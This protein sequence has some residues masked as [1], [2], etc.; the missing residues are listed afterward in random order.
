MLLLQ[1]CW[2]ISVPSPPSTTSAGTWGRGAAA[3][4]PAA[5]AA[6]APAGRIQ[7]WSRKTQDKEVAP[8]ARDEVPPQVLP[9]DPCVL[10]HLGRSQCPRSWLPWIP[11]KGLASG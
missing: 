5:A 10:W 2:P 7:A 3:A 4:G 6:P 1:S 9:F 8:G 11:P